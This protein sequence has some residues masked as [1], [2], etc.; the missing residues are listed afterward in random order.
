M[1]KLTDRQRLEHGGEQMKRT[2]GYDQKCKDLA[3][4]FLPEGKEVSV[5][6]LAQ[7]IQDAIEDWMGDGVARY[8]LDEEDSVPCS[9]CG[10]QQRHP[11]TGLLSCECPS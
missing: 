11:G 8:R 6:D 4:Q 7:T 9:V 5:A 3:G 2:K 1:R 10:S